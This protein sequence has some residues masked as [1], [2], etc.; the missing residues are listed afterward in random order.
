[1]VLMVLQY[2]SLTTEGIGPGAC[3]AYLLALLAKV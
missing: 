3:A 2:G 1:M